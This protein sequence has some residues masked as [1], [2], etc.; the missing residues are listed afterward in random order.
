M[1]APLFGLAD[2]NADMLTYCFMVLSANSKAVCLSVALGQQKEDYCCDRVGSLPT[3]SRIFNLYKCLDVLLALTNLFFIYFF[4]CVFFFQFE[5]PLI[6]SSTIHL[7]SDIVHISK[8]AQIMDDPYTG[9]CFTCLF[10]YWETEGGGPPPHDTQI[11][12]KHN[13]TIYFFIHLGITVFCRKRFSNYCLLESSTSQ[14]FW[15]FF[16]SSLIELYVI[17]CQLTGCQYQMLMV[18]LLI[19]SQC[20]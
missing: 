7:N 14:G 16:S 10:F 6:F 8:S 3:S 1:L 13:N 17:T 4:V 19:L 18:S 5:R 2:A 12:P 11:L 15:I 9:N 20:Q